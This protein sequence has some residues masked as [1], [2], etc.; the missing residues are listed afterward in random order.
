M[1]HFT[2]LTAALLSA[3]TA[4]LMGGGYYQLMLLTLPAAT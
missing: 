1:K 2:R 4:F 3:A